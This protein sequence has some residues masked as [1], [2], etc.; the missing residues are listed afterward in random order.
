MTQPRWPLE[1]DLAGVT[2]RRDAEDAD[3]DRHDDDEP[4]SEEGRERGTSDTDVFLLEGQQLR[5]GTA[6]AWRARR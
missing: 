5:Y 1:Y 6:A 4:T 3:D 2:T